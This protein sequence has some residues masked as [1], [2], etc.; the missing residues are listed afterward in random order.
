MPRNQKT[1]ACPFLE[2]I[3]MEYCRAYPVRKPVP[4]H[5]ITTSTPCSG[6]DYRDC[7]FFQEVISRLACAAVGEPKDM[8]KRRS[9]K[10]V[11]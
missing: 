1:K 3:V 5:K 2:E 10:E 4:K 7:P 6:E 8:A 11:K 9:W